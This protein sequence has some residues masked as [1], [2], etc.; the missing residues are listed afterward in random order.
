MSLQRR[1]HP[2]SLQAPPPQMRMNPAA[3]S[4]SYPGVPMQIPTST[5][6]IDPRSMP[7][8]IWPQYYAQHDPRSA[9]FQPTSFQNAAPPSRPSVPRMPYPPFDNSKHGPWD[10]QGRGNSSGQ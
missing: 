8:E 5:T 9:S 3:V 2:S 10:Q 6:P 4:S 7:T 1:Q